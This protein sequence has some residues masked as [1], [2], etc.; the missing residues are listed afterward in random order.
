MSFASRFKDGMEAYARDKSQNRGIY[1]MRSTTVR[2]E[3]KDT[4]DK[5]CRKLKR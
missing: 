5:I 1:P 2:L 3:R 4:V